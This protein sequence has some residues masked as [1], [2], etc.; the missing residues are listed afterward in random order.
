MREIGIDLSVHRSKSLKEVPAGPYDAVVTMGCG[1]DCP[2]I[3]AKRREDWTLP[4]PKD[5]PAEEVRKVRDR[6]EERVFELL[7]D[8]GISP[9]GST[10]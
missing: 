7:A 3:P 4:D 1:D 5:L 10:E 6:I 9:Q 8:L 2:A